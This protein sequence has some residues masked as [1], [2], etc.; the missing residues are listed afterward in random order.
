MHSTFWPGG[1][2]QTHTHTELVKH[3]EVD[4]SIRSGQAA[5]KTLLCWASLLT[6]ATKILARTVDPSYSGDASR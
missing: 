4:A 3:V 2:T 5:V 1:K 6:Q